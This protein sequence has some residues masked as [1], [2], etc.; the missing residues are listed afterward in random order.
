MRHRGPRLQP[1]VAGATNSALWPGTEW[2][3][4]K[5]QS[6]FEGQREDN[7]GSFTAR[8]ILWYQVA[9][10]QKV[11]TPREYLPA[12]GQS[13]AGIA[14]DKDGN[15]RAQRRGRAGARRRERGVLALAIGCIVPSG[16]P[17]EEGRR[18]GASARNLHGRPA[19][20]SGSTEPSP[21]DTGRHRDPW[22]APLEPRRPRDLRTTQSAI[23]PRIVHY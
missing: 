8:S 23:M 21:R 7:C 22:R 13:Y 4:L 10:A 12:F 19:S 2:L 16:R 9:S 20:R 18:L 3:N 15:S 1:F 6:D 17:R 11:W 14:K 5:L